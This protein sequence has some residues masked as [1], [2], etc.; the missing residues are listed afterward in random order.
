MNFQRVVF[1]C[2]A[3]YHRIPADLIK[4]LYSQ[5]EFAG[6]KIE[7]CNDL[8]YEAV[9][10][11]EFLKQLSDENTAIAACYRRS[12]KALFASVD[13][14]APMVL[15][16]RSDKINQHLLT[17]G[18]N[19][20][21]KKSELLIPEY[22][23]KWKAWYP[24]IDRERCS[25]CGKCIDYCLFGVYS[26]IGR[27]VVVAQPSECKTNC[28]ACAR[29]CPQKAIIFPKHN[30]APIDGAEIEPVNPPKLEVQP[31]QNADDLYT[32]LAK[33]RQNQKKDALLK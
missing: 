5:A 25:G 18:I 14:S 9:R 11:P 17:L 15:D 7:L 28:P 16:L 23:Y 6:I 4:G 3:D 21:E 2:C 8:C 26:R 19:A 33:R 10:N 27:R 22:A 29:V 12:I 30:E 31:G 1:C 20:S 32:K 24:L 13:I